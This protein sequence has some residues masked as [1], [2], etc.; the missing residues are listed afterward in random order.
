MAK[1]EEVLIV[2][3][4]N[5]EVVRQCNK[6]TDSINLYKIMRETLVLLTQ[7]DYADGERI[8]TNK[9]EN[10]MNGSEWSW[11]KL[12]TLCWAIG[13]I[14]GVMHEKNERRLLVKV[15]DGLLD[16]YEKK[17]GK[18]DKAII[19]SNLMYVAGEYP[20]FLRNHRRFFKIVVNKLFEF[21]HEHHHGVKV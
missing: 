9:L 14:S 17:E 16:L 2:K 4:E 15:L 19:A 21:M 8:M 11:M 6:D 20:K 18:Y 13:S 10:L 1:P 3:N 7:L 5:G 12:N